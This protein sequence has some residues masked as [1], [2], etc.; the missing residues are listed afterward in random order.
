MIDLL[1]QDLPMPLILAGISKW[2]AMSNPA[3]RWTKWFR[4]SWLAALNC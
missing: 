2:I 3:D 4:M 1:N